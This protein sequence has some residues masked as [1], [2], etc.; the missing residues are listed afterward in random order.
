MD[1]LF[2]EE[3]E[4]ELL[5]V[6][7]EDSLPALLEVLS[8]ACR[9]FGLDEALPEPPARANDV[10]YHVIS[11]EPGAMTTSWRALPWLTAGARA[12]A[13]RSWR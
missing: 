8:T 13:G 10:W 4:A 1:E 5:Y 11:T 9:E 12:E 6:T 2:G 7:H 3:A